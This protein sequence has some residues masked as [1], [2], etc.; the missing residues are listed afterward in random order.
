MTRRGKIKYKDVV[1][2]RGF[3]KPMKTKKK[4]IQRKTYSLYKKN[5]KSENKGLT[6]KLENVPVQQK[7]ENNE[8]EYAVDSSS[9]DEVNPFQDLIKTFKNNNAKTNLAI[10]S[11][12]ESEKEDENEKMEEDIEN[13]TGPKSSVNE[14]TIPIAHEDDDNPNDQEEEI[15]LD[16]QIED[17]FENPGDPFSKHIS[18]ELN[19]S[20]LTSVQS[21]PMIF[22]THNEFWPILGNLNI[23]IPKCNQVGIENSF[24]L[25]DKKTF[26]LEGSIPKRISKT[27]TLEELFIKSQIIPNINKSNVFKDESFSP[28]QFE[29]FS[30]I[31]NYQDLYFPQETFFNM[32]QVRFIYCLHAVNHILKTRIKV[33]HHNGKLSTRKD[34]P[35]EFRDQGLVRPKVLILL[36][37]KQS[38][39]KVVM[40]IIQLILSED[41]GNVINKNRFVEDYT[42]NEILFPKKNPKP[43]DY[44]QIFQGNTND[45][46]KIGMTITKKSIKVSKHFYFNYIVQTFNNFKSVILSTKQ[47]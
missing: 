1:K 44:E 15:D 12:S 18:Y 27:K 30:I 23:Q 4:Q 22:N 28:L 14:E 13:I 24:A 32:E 31:N 42:G 43:E 39:Y 41:K 9:E 2:K 7:A 33:I 34:V 38:A 37:F 19:E 29:L 16:P 45:D 8:P 17:A 3:Q 5:I 26:A 11:S 40:F 6:E 20:L 46:F 36:P 21:V 25:I 10:E 47:Y 35:E